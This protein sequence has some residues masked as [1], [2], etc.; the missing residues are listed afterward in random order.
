M[1]F[2]VLREKPFHLSNEDLEWV[3]STLAGLTTDEKI[4]QLFF[5]VGYQQDEPFL[6]RLAGEIGVGG[7]MCRSMDKDS[8]MAAVSTLQSS[9]PI[10]LL[11]AAN[12][13]A[14]GQG[15][16]KD[17]TKVG[18]NLAIAATTT[19]SLLTN[20]G[21]FAPWKEAALARTTLSR[22]RRRGF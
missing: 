6:K 16:T 3:K 22:R 15:I 9:A 17:G 2:N 4:G 12:L 8:V 21:G 18:S 10:P 20:W 11:I 1:N 13:E 7:L 19:R 14:G 5:M